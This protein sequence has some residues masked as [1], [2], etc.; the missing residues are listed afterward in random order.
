VSRGTPYQL[1]LGAGYGTWEWDLATDEST[2]S[3]ELYA[4]LGIS[5]DAALASQSAFTACVHT[6]DLT[7]VAL[8]LDRVRRDG[9]RAE[10]EHRIMRPPSKAVRFVRLRAWRTA[11]ERR[12]HA[13][14]EDVTSQ[15]A[16]TDRLSSVSAFAAGVAHEINNP[17]GFLSANLELIDRELIAAEVDRSRELDV[18]M[19][20]ARHGI[21][22][23]HTVVRGLMTFSRVE[24]THHE[25][26]D[27][28]RVIE[29]ALGIAHT[30]IRQRARLVRQFTP[31]PPVDANA[32]RLGQVFVNLLLNAA[33]AIP[34]GG[35]AD[36]EIA[37]ATSVDS[38]NR[39]V[40]EIR[41]TGRGIPRS[42][43]A[44]AFE[45]FVTTKPVGAG[46]GLGLT[47]CRNIVNAIGGEIGFESEPGKTVFRVVLP[48]TSI[49]VKHAPSE[50]SIAMTTRRGSVL[51]VDDE[52]IFATSL[53][54]LLAREHDVEIAKHGREAL[55][56]LRAGERFDAIISDLMMP[57]FGGMELY[58]NTVQL[59][60]E[61]AERFIFVTA[62]GHEAAEF[63]SRITN[64]WFDKP[65]DL[66]ALR[67]AIRRLVG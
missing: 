31:L 58:A 66:D 61:Q 11:D 25:P 57:G 48:S 46:P 51:I 65:C 67:A 35:H 5:P 28:N 9:A 13:L 4:I 40:V 16:I 41:D 37:V 3:D 24:P 29:V 45:A 56:R 53:R 50:P 44:R 12:M 64:P 21:H 10:L 34:T 52:L 1:D 59:A 39:I 2:W 63:L 15:S 18:L 17:L 55:D 27:I 62:G 60:A 6:D 36:H 14:V 54:R 33:Q 43:G 30:E 47:V 26:L 38:S 8:A 20:E 22:R 42:L 19:R 32:A 7:R 23:I 49:A